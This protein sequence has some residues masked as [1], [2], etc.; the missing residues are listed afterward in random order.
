MEILIAVLIVAGI[1]WIGYRHYSKK[2]D[3]DSSAPYKVE[4]PSLVE[5]TVPPVAQPEP[6]P[7]KIPEDGKWPFPTSTPPGGPNDRVEAKEPVKKPKKNP[8][9]AAPKEPKATKEPKMAK[10][11]KAKPELKVVDNKPGRGKK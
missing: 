9:K 10:P 2:V 7:T 11:K 1:A 4:T 8:V 6:Q 5:P 3:S